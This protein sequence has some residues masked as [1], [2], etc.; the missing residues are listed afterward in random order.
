MAN[1][2]FGGGDGSIEKPYL[3]ED[4][5]DLNAIR[6]NLLAHYKIVKNIDMTQVCNE[7]N[8]NG[9]M[10]IEDFRG[11]L[12]GNGFSVR[13][14]FI[15][16]V[17]DYQAL[18]KSLRGGAIMNLGLVAVNIVGGSKYCAPLVG[19]MTTQDDLVENCFAT[20]NL[21]A[22]ANI[23][24]LVGIVDGGAIINSFSDVDITTTGTYTA[25]LVSCLNNEFSLI[26]NCYYSGTITGGSSGAGCVG[27]KVNGKV[28][29]CFFD[30]TKNLF[31]TAD[32]L[33][34]DK[35][36]TADSFDAW[37]KE[38]Y[39]F[40]K[41]VWVLRDGAYPK[42]FFTEATKY[43]VFTDN[44]YKT[45]KDGQWVDVSTSFPAESDFAEHGMN[46]DELAQVP[47]FKWNMLRKFKTFELVAS[48]DK[49]VIERKIVKQDMV[50]DSQ[51]ADATILKATIDFSKLG[52]SINR[53]RVVQ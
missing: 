34:T 42:L 38:F 46:A 1:G 11:T 40:E 50:V 3:I 43:F 9:W 30:S 16:R 33:S 8:G 36:Q 24:G 31:T 6:D 15:N 12:E 39:N 13:N 49:F 19:W 44:V 20:G 48:T 7:Q 5:Y 17:E 2:K 35:M 22:G 27:Q 14:L 10:P 53:I 4:G 37:R 52:D 32:G 26:K 21:S 23:G 28:E 18:F 41:P 45:Y 25:G 51:I 29:N 47:R